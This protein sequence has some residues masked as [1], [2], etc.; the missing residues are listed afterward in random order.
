MDPVSTPYKIRTCHLLLRRQLL[1]PGELRAHCQK[2]ES[3][4]VDYRP[5][6]NTMKGLFCDMIL[7]HESFRDS[8]IHIS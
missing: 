6:V 2:T 8:L 3:I 1:Y 5:F 4:L 7:G